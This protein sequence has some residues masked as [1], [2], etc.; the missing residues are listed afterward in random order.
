MYI[1]FQHSYYDKE[2]RPLLTPVEF[3]NFAPLVVIDCSRQNETLNAGTVDV[4]LEFETNENM[5]N[6]TSAHCLILHDR[7]IKYNPLTGSIRTL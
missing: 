4:R 1:Q 2:T 7:I 6:N 5:P 3:M